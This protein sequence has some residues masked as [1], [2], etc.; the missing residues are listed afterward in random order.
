MEK[1]FEKNYLKFDEINNYD[2]TKNED[3]FNTIEL[4]FYDL[5]DKKGKPI[6]PI[7]K[8]S[9]KHMVYRHKQNKS[10]DKAYGGPVRK[11][12][13]K[14]FV[15][16]FTNARDVF[17]VFYQPKHIIDYEKKIKLLAMEQL[18]KGFV[19]FDK[20]A[21]VEEIIYAFRFLSSHPNKLKDKFND[22]IVK[23]K[24]TKPDLIENLNK[25][26]WDALEG[27]VIRDD[28]II[29]SLEKAAKIYAPKSYIYIKMRGF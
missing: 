9:M 4:L 28:A 2:K 10:Y 26:L 24:H 15:N 25:P 12:D 17:E 19:M 29:G 7:S 18:P 22:G 11:N 20:V 1:L 16:K 14:L 6:D 21:H 8:Q 3:L 13:V 27:V 5:H 23:F